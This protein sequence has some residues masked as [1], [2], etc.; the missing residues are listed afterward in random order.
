MPHLDEVARQAAWVG[1]GI[2]PSSGS[3]PA[4]GTLLTGLRPWLHQAIHEGRPVLSPDLQ[5]LAEALHERGYTTAG[6]PGDPWGQESYGFSQGFDAFVKLGRGRRALDRLANLGSGRHFVWVHLPEPGAPYVR[7]DQY[8]ERLGPGAPDLPRRLGDAQLEPFFDPATPLPPGLRR[9]FLSMYRL[10]AAWADE[11]LGQFLSALRA[12]GQWDRTL[13]V[14]TSIHGEE[15]GEHG[16]ILHGGNLGRAG[17]E[18]PLIVKL[19]KGSPLHLRPPAVQRV[20]TARLWATLVEAVGGEPPP[21]AAPSLWRDAPPEVVSELYL[22][23]GSNRFSLVDGDLQLLQESRFA[24]PAP[25]Y[26]QARQ[27]ALQRKAQ[28]PPSP[29]FV[30]LTQEFD[31]MPPFAGDG[32]AGAQSWRLERWLAAGGTARVEDPEKAVEMARRL[33]DGWHRFV[34]DELSPEGESSAG[35]DP[36]KHHGRWRKR[37]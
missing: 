15:F 35:K 14:I 9:R 17:L 6:Y 2:A 28:A 25:D 30:R 10:N 8:L 34:P 7:Y 16:Q 36:E 1:R 26:F 13:L 29:V 22:T 21:A 19:P 20:A 11:R 3:V 37:R 4:L 23:N 27:A 31:R 24:A 12:S 33:A 32:G 18:V 5:T